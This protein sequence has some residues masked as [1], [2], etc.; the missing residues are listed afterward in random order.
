M[1]LF[2]TWGV[3][4]TGYRLQVNGE[5]YFN[6]GLITQNITTNYFS[7]YVPS[8]GNNVT[9]WATNS[10]GVSGNVPYVISFAPKSFGCSSSFT[11]SPNP[12]TSAVN[13]SVNTYDIQ[14]TPKKANHQY[15]R[16]IE[17]ADK[18]G[19]IRKR[20]SYPVNTTRVTIDVSGLPTDVYI[21]RIF[22]GKNWVEQKIII[23]K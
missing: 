9:I 6:N 8:S 19:A 5:G 23:K 12:A 20:Y 21:V 15:C 1:N 4:G 22:D 7:V 17:I 18:L 2:G 10:C 11:V 14:T 13:I 3:G 16:K